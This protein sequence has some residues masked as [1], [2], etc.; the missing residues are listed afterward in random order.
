M[1]PAYIIVDLVDLSDHGE[2]RGDESTAVPSSRRQLVH[3][4]Q[5]L[6]LDR[7]VERRCRLSAISDRRTAI[8][9]IAIITR[10]ADATGQV[11][12]HRS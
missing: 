8:S 6:A 3:Q 10:L 7:D 5:D 11:D 1:R 9:A 2:V 12:V 4:A